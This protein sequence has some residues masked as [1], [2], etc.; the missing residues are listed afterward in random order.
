M[1]QLSSGYTRSVSGLAGRAWPKRPFHGPAVS[2]NTAGQ[3]VSSD[4]F[5]RTLGSVGPTP[6]AVAL[7]LLRAALRVTS[8]LS[9]P[10]WSS[11]DRGND[12]G[13]AG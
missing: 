10:P 13:P 1:R 2:V 3:L 11:R 9:P 4:L 6:T 8:D 7:P 5:T 12:R